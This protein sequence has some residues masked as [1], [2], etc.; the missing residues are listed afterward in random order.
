MN[1][2]NENILL[3]SNLIQTKLTRKITPNP[4]PVVGQAFRR[5]F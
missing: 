3:K 2:V 5:G 1:N 4:P